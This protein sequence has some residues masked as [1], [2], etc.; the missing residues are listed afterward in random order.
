M[1]FLNIML[2]ALLKKFDCV[3]NLADPPGLRRRH[4]YIKVYPNISE[5]IKVLT[6]STNKV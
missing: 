1:F 4:L 5:N 2:K 3:S 6:V